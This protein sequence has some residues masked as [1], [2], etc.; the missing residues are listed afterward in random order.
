M[1]WTEARMI[2]WSFYYVNEIIII[3]FIQNIQEY[4]IKKNKEGKFEECRKNLIH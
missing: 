2:W 3:N 4:Y 1:L